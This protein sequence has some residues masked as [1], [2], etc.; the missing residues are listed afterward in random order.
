MT[1]AKVHIDPWRPADAQVQEVLAQLRPILPI[2]FEVVR[3]KVRIPAQHYPKVIG[4]LKAM[5]KLSDEQWLGDGSY[6]AVVEIPGGM[7]TELSEKLKARTKGAAE[8]TLV[9]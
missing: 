8:T 4:E 2:R 3:V 5:G 9:K 7:Q 6:S 1:E